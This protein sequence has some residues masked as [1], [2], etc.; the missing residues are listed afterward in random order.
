M[1]SWYGEFPSS[2]LGWGTRYH[3]RDSYRTARYMRYIT[4]RNI[5]TECDGST[6]G[7]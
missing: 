3:V 6:E 7:S 2:I 5:A 1:S 4:T